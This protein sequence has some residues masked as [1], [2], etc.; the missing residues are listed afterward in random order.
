MSVSPASSKNNKINPLILR[1]FASILLASALVF[2]SGCV[3]IVAGGAAGG[4]TAYALGDLEVSLNATAKETQRA[5]ERG[6]D[7]LGLRK[8][9]GGGDELQGEYVY[10]TAADKKVTIKYNSQTPNV[11]EL[12]IRV[13]TFG[14]ESFSQ[15]IYNAIQNRL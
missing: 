6:A 7:D 1:F 3:A 8:V 5:I 10:R 15:R 12:N 9:S 14:D 13:G 11:M 2:N 4:G